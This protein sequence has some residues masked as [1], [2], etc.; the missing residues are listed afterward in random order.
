MMR[1]RLDRKRALL[2][3]EINFGWTRIC[4]KDRS[5]VV[6]KMQRLG[7]LQVNL[8]IHC[9]PESLSCCWCFFHSWINIR[10]SSTFFFRCWTNIV[11]FAK[12]GVSLFLFVYRVKGPFRVSLT[13]VLLRVSTSS[14]ASI[15][16]GTLTQSFTW[17][18]WWD[19]NSNNWGEKEVPWPESVM[20]RR[21]ARVIKNIT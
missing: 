4:W 18:W 14:N 3:R 20:R 6:T 10:R 13:R 1:Q 2:P 17:S 8:S 11:K 15:I 12:S 7:W 9:I 21:V 19:T 5:S 16:P